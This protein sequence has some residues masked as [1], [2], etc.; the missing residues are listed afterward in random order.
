MKLDAGD[1]KTLA[2]INRPARGVTL[3]DIVEGLKSMPHLI[4]QSVLV[5]GPVSNVRGE[6]YQAWL[7][8]LAEI[9][10]ARVQIYSTDRPVPDAGVERVPPATLE[11]IADEIREQARLQ[12][13][14]YWVQN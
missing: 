13:E 1:Q 14:A 3:E 4:I 11:H 8:A 9:Q 6:A 5:D 10:P 2:G 12:V 7:T